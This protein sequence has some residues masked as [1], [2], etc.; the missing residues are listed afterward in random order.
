MFRPFRTSEI[1]DYAFS[2]SIFLTIKKEFYRKYAIRWS[3][4]YKIAEPKSSISPIVKLVIYN[5]Q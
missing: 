5:L 3:T 4:L 2:I 1:E